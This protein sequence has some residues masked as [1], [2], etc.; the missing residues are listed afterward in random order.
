M[1]LLLLTFLLMTA[2][3]NAKPGAGISI[4]AS[5]DLKVCLEE[6]VK[7]FRTSTPGNEF[8]INYA[9]SSQAF[10][11]IRNGEEFDMFFS[12]DI[13]YIRRLDLEGYTATPARL[14][15]IGRLVLWSATVDASQVPLSS[16]NDPQFKKVAIA[17]PVFSPYGQRAAE[18]LTRARI[19]QALQPKLLLGESLAGT[20]TSVR[21]GEATI[22]ILP[23]THVSGAAFA[24]QKYQLIPTSMHSPLEYTVTILYDAR[25]N[26]AARSFLTFLDTPPA[27]TIFR[28]NGFI[29]PTEEH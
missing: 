9:S 23:L 22:G 12:A 27:R 20:V 29:L 21:N 14:Y 24:N 7:A 16:L 10:D 3:A 6:L 1:H 2:I 28:Q 8:D 11:R 13:E 4:V 18:V 5:G 25:R 15:A 19:L 17:N 26:K